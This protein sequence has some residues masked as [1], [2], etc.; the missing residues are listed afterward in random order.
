MAEANNAVRAAGRAKAAGILVVA[1]CTEN[2]F[3]ACPQVR[4]MASGT[5]YYFQTRGTSGLTRVFR[6]IA[7]DLRDINLRQLTVSEALPQGLDL[8]PDSAAPPPQLDPTGR[9]LSWQFRFVPGAGVTY[10]YAVT[11]SEVTTYSLA[12]STVTFQ[13]SQDRTGLALVPTA[14][15]TVTDDCAVPTATPTLGPSATPTPTPVP[16][17]TA[18]PTPIPGVRYLP[19]LGF[20]RCL[21]RDRPLDVVLA[22]DAS[23]SMRGATSAGRS[24]LEAAKEGA[25]HFVDLMADGERTAVLDFNSTA[26]LGRSLTDDKDALR[27]AI[28]GIVVSPGTRIDLA[29]TQAARELLGPARQPGASP[30]IVLLT[31]GQPTGTTPEAVMAAAQEARDAGISVFTIGLGADVDSALLVEVAGSGDRY[32]FAPDGED[33]ARIYAAVREK[34]PCDPGFGPATPFLPAGPPD[35]W[36]PG[37]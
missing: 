16:S 1:V 26:N 30:V 28:D 10:T 25:R 23:T 14:V 5:R 9:T 18:T 15:L 12:I 17:A 6:E 35:Y 36:E 24:K 21:E 29:L 19:I 20:G 32:F 31:D 13:D 22:I 7:D 3:S 33:L 4:Q 8:V 2:A 11:P 37:R 34:L 27:A